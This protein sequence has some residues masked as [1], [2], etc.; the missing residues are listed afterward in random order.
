[1][2]IALASPVVVVALAAAMSSV[3]CG[4]TG[5][6][7]KDTSG[8]SG[9]APSGAIGWPGTDWSSECVQDGE[10][11][12]SDADCCWSPCVQSVCG[13]S[14]CFDEGSACSQDTDCCPGLSCMLD[15]AG[16]RACGQPSTSCVPTG[17][18]CSSDADCCSGACDPV[19]LTCN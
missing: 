15:S 7:V 6:R 12:Y 14:A 11:C 2:R 8:D 4:P 1:M 18:A 13:G 9:W 5:E 16:N 3:A 17:S 10:G 19:Q